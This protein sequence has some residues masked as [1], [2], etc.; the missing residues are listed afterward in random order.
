MDGRTSTSTT[1]S[2]PPPFQLLHT[3]TPH[4]GPVHAARLNSL[5]RYLLTAGA[6]RQVH[7]FNASSSTTP[8]IIKS[9]SAHSG[10]VLTLS[11]ASDSSTFVSGGEDRNVLQWDVASG[12]VVRR[13]SAHTGAVQVASFCGAQGSPNDVLLT[14]GFDGVLRFYDMRARGAWKPI[15]E[16]KDAKDTILTA[17]AKESCIWTGSVDGVVRT[18]DLRAGQL[19]EDTV[20]REYH[21][22]P[23]EGPHS[24]INVL[25]PIP[26]PVASI[27]PTIT[28]TSL[29][30]SMLA[31][32]GEKKATH[33]VLDLSDGS[34]LQSI[35]GGPNN[36]YRC[37]SILHS[38]DSCIVAGDE[39]GRVKMWD[40][41]SG[42]ERPFTRP[43]AATMEHAK[44][45]LSL[46]ATDKE[47]GKVV[48]AA[49]D[50]SVRIW[51]P[52]S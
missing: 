6:D 30:I 1:S 42:K 23:Q 45:V 41:L 29:L 32:Q 17:T 9:Y 13:F 51:A 8:S 22:F 26:G 35:E 24:E 49:A 15:M 20:D 2:P 40:I 48:S 36:Q 14:A 12:S 5:G 34:N 39:D 38:G 31:R 21:C 3:L 16:C 28:S 19:Q 46:E 43:G 10:A 47:G 37:P 27:T 44:A 33:A 52:L 25:F 50:G 4:K 7:L 11:I 18:Y